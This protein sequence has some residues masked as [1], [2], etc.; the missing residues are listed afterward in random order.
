MT[1]KGSDYSSWQAPNVNLDG[2]DF[3]IV[4]TTEGVS[5]VNPNAAAQ[6]AQVK[7]RGLRAAT[8]HFADGDDP[9]NEARH[10][11]GS[12]GKQGIQALD[13][14]HPAVDQIA[15]PP[16]WC[17]AFLDEVLRLT[18]NKGVLYIDGATLIRFRSTWHKVSDGDYGLWV[19]AW[20]P[21]GPPADV[22]PWPFAALW[23]YAD[24]SQTGGDADIFEADAAAW[25][26]YA[27]NTGSLPPVVPTSTPT[28][29]APAP[30]A[31]RPPAPAPAPADG[32]IIWNVDPGDT[33]S[34][35]ANAVG[36]SLAALE[37]VNPGVNPNLIYPGQ[38][39]RLPAGARWPGGPA[40]APVPGGPTEWIVDPGDTMGAIA[41]AVH[42]T[43][44]ALEAANPG[45]NPNLI[46][47][48]QVLRLPAGARWPG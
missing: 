15:D 23:Q 18:G 13:M 1:L 9:V 6:L 27:G 2:L 20:N 43:L 17:R 34:G 26:A 24:T 38:V 48:K 30:P 8:Y 12:F 11:V 19:A 40:P 42:V 31:P 28:P 4:K 5:Y 47:P 41:N 29:P 36:V 35:I 16:A 10:Y 44:G 33:M 3:A 37:S 46:F 14:E 21:T 39:L 45:V 25:D 22:S 7:A 32:P